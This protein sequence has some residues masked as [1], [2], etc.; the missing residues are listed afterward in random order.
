MDDIQRLTLASRSMLD[1]E[2][3]PEL[4]LLLAIEAAQYASDREIY[5]L[6]TQ[7][8]DLLREAIRA[9][10]VRVTL[11]GHTAR[12]NS[13]HYNATGKH[14]ITTSDDGTARI[15]DASTGKL[16]IPLILKK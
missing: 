15:W 14:I 9:S 4:A 1:N 10:N 7:L 3:D 6:D 16:V 13:V 5:D 12:V 8:E 11:I 2:N